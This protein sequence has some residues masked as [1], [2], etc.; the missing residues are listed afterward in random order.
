MDSAGRQ[1][2]VHSKVTKPFVISRGKG[3]PVETRL[4]GDSYTIATDS[5]VHKFMC[6]VGAVV[7]RPDGIHVSPCYEKFVAKRPHGS[8]R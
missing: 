6:G 3:G 7:G 1:I 4:G 2:V 5:E 8:E